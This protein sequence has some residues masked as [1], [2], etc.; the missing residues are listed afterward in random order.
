MRKEWYNILLIEKNDETGEEKETVIA[1]VKSKGNAYM[2][3][4]TLKHTYANQKHLTV[5]LEY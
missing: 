2:V 3:F 5:K 4:K 1:K